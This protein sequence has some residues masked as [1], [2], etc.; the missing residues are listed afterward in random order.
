MVTVGN[1]DFT[2][3]I[4]SAWSSGPS[5]DICRFGTDRYKD[6]FSTKDKTEH[7]A[8]QS[9]FTVAIGECHWNGKIQKAKVEENSMSTMNSYTGYLADWLYN[10]TQVYIAVS[11]DSTYL[12]F[13]VAGV[14]QDYLEVVIKDF[15]RFL[16]HEKYRMSVKYEESTG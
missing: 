2:V 9:S 14:A 8:S 1:S 10:Q 5:G 16:N 13:S 12:D 15:D 7:L 4:S 11:K 3:T 6:R